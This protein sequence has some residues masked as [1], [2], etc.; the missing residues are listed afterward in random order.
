M[1]KDSPKAI[2]HFLYNPLRQ[3][4]EELKQLFVA[5]RPL[6]ERLYSEIVSHAPDSVPQH[7]LI[8]GQRGMG[9]TTLLARLALELRE[10]Q[11]DFLPLAFWEEQHIEVDRLSVFWLNCLDSLA[12]ALDVAGDST[13]AREL[14]RKVDQIKVIKPEDEC[15]REA[16]DAFGEAN[17]KLG[18]RLVLFI[19]NF[20]L[21]LARLKKHD[22]V[23]R[24]FFTRQ[25]APIIVGAAITPPADLADYDA[26]FYDGFKTTLLHRLSLEETKDMIIRLA[27]EYGQLEAVQNMWRELP[28]LSALRDLSG[29][30]P[31]TSL[32]IYRLCAQGFSHDIY[33]DL[34]ALL[35]ETT[36][37]FQSRFELLSDQGQKLIARLARHWKPATAETITELTGFPRGTVSPL[38]GRLEEEGMIEKVSMYDPDRRDNPRQKRGGLSKRVG[39]QLTERFFNIW[40]IM[41]SASRRER[42]GIMCLSR[43]LESIYSPAERAQY[44]QELSSCASL[45]WGQA[46]GARALAETIEHS[47]LLLKA[48]TALLEMVK[49]GD[50]ELE[51]LIDPSNIDHR[52]H[53]LV[54]LRSLIRAAVP[55]SA[56]T[57][58]EEF[59]NLVMGSFSMLI[60][61]GMSQN[62]IS[63]IKKSRLVMVD[64]AAESL[65]GESRDFVA[66]IGQESTDWLQQRIRSGL[67]TSG[68][69]LKEVEDAINAVDHPSLAGALLVLG[70]MI[71]EASPATA[72]RAYKKATE[73]KDDLYEAWAQL[74]II[75]QSTKRHAEARAAYAKALTLGDG[76]AAILSNYGQLLAID[77]GQLEE[78]SKWFRRAAK[79]DPRS[80]LIA[81]NLGACLWHM[82]GKVN[83]EAALIEFK[84]AGELDLFN[85]KP[86]ITMG[87]I[88]QQ[89]L[90]NP[91]AAETCFRKAISM[92]SK[93]SVARTHLGL[94]LLHSYGKF[95]EA[96]EQFRR[97]IAD[98]NENAAC[99][100]GL[101]TVLGEH[102][103]QFVESE[104]AYRK[105]IELEPQSPIAWAGLGVLQY[106]Y[107][108]QFENARVSY[109]KAAELA[110]SDPRY[111][112]SLGNLE[113]DHFHNTEAAEQHFR[114]A[115]ELNPSEDSARH[116]YAFMLRDTLGRSAEAKELLDKL[117][118]PDSWKD[119]QALHRALFAAYDH[120]WGQAMEA[121]KCALG[122][123]KT[124]T[125]PKNT[126]DDWCRASAVLIKLGFG[127]KLLEF[128]ES[129]GIHETMMPWFEALKAHVIGDRQLLLNIP[130]EAR[131]ASGILFDEIA[132]R[133]PL[134]RATR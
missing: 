98:G 104:A 66:Q 65:R 22:H 27:E 46:I 86:W 72:E 7:Q 42:A 13:S 99:W 110:P 108:G 102:K 21:L 33:R 56:K 24:S 79:R 59:V 9:K 103:H 124:S 34:E 43:F 129:E 14:D 16:R 101:A 88:Y 131:D 105:A 36:P 119:T 32:L 62:I 123:I 2:R 48:D 83:A 82:G 60:P 80:A 126:H 76:S 121:L 3:D 18:R 106:L 111:Q 100:L 107:T 85:P 12:D 57:S 93:A 52:A 39:Y 109:A 6:F 70:E 120:N 11:K 112:N 68:E 92:S 114:R 17:A 38:L 78:A 31:R 29:G 94:L 20:N 128:L 37:L 134:M 53:Q 122:E 125:F 89:E 26:A 1:N 84:R 91:A 75:Y 5:R 87:S 58:P 35:D 73:L 51:G 28:R 40:I 41:R 61:N 77:F 96:E 67:L 113:Y 132:I 23:L 54:D 25:G 4:P 63:E 90:N 130:A 118:Q 115:L 47:E 44:A 8:I 45:S 50:G 81:N 117:S 97:A 74:G 116:N 49:R 95:I 133:L 71:Q 55:A 127:D 69:N 30:N 64:R 10:K 15:A 19:D